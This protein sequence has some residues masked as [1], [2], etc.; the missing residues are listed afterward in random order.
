VPRGAHR[1]GLGGLALLIALAWREAP[2]QA[3]PG[4]DTAWPTTRLG[5]A[6]WSIDVWGHHAGGALCW[7]EGEPG[8]LRVEIGVLPTGDPR[9]SWLAD[10]LARRGDGWTLTAASGTADRSPAYLLKPWG[11]P[12]RR[13]PGG[14]ADALR[15]IVATLDAGPLDRERGAFAA[16]PRPAPDRPRTRGWRRPGRR[17]D[18]R[19]IEIPPLR[20]DPAAA[21]SSDAA[22]DRAAVQVPGDGGGTPPDPVASR[23]RDSGALRRSLVA[24]GR[25]RGGA[26]EL[27]ALAWSTGK[28]G[29]WVLRVASSRR[30]GAVVLRPRGGRDVRYP[31]WEA[32]VPVWAL[33]ELLRFP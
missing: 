16:F 6:L 3:T 31:G 10:L 30:P 25:G 15:E 21:D 14:A 5:T 17:D 8:E 12:W 32:F 29:A 22:G 19:H 27:L 1:L 24:R 7:L 33:A 11:R 4:E 20:F 9:D 2:A 26:G 28:S 13:L 23:A 18:R